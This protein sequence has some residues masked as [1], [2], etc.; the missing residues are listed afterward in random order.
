M[1]KTL[2]GFY[3]RKFLENAIGPSTDEI[4]NG[5]IVG[6]RK[7][8]VKRYLE[9][10]IPWIEKHY[11]ED[12]FVGYLIVWKDIETKICI[13]TEIREYPIREKRKPSVIKFRR[14][15]PLGVVGPAHI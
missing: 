7:R 3:D 15:A 2:A 12:D 8:R 4:F 6:W 14:Y 1:E 9:F 13:G 5:K 11:D 10:K